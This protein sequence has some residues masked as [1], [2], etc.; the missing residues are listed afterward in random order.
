MHRSRSV[1]CG[2]RSGV[3]KRGRSFSKRRA[4]LI[5]RSQSASG[6]APLSLTS[7]QDLS[8]PLL[9]SKAPHRLWAPARLQDEIPG[10]W[11]QRHL[12]IEVRERLRRDDDGLVPDWVE[13]PPLHGGLQDFL[14]H[15]HRDEGVRV[16]ARTAAVQIA[17]LHD[18]NEELGLRGVAQRRE[19]GFAGGHG[20]AKGPARV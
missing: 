2:R 19:G 5:L 15:F 8:Q 4:S 18:L 13:A 16:A 3:Q 20:C 11:Q 6:A 7:L 12:A 14:A 10:P 17:R 1:P 9:S